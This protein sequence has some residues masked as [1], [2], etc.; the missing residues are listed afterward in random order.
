MC[1]VWAPA[2]FWVTQSYFFLFLSLFIVN[3]QKLTAVAL[4][5]VL[6]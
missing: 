3:V 2:F 4:A 1:N 5:L 6:E